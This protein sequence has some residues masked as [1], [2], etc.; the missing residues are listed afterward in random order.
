M[1]GFDWFD[2]LVIAIQLLVAFF[3]AYLAYRFVRI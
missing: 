1:G 3:V 2:M